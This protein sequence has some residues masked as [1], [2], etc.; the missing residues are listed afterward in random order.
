MYIKNWQKWVNFC[1]WLNG[2]SAPIQNVTRGNSS[3]KIS[4]LWNINDIL[5]MSL[6]F[7]LNTAVKGCQCCSLPKYFAN[8]FCDLQKKVKHIWNLVNDERSRDHTI[9]KDLA[10]T[11]NVF[12]IPKV[13]GLYS[14]TLWSVVTSFCKL[15]VILHFCL[16]N[17]LF[18]VRTFGSSNLCYF[19]FTLTCPI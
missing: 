12:D 17:L 6:W 10:A 14:A 18:A 3:P 19:N 8:V 11:E 9:W 5:E 4:F 15:H 7:C 2:Y 1:F 13:F 16:F